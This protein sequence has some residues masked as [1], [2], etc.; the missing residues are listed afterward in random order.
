MSTHSESEVNKSPFIPQPMWRRVLGLP[1]S[2]LGVWSVRCVEAFCVFLCIFIAL[3]WGG[4]RGGFSFF[5]NP[6]LAT[7]VLG[8]LVSGIAGG[9][10]AAM[11]MLKKQE[12]SIVVFLVFLWGVFVLVFA[13]GELAGRR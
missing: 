6:W 5:S 10:M 11:A 4:L 1:G 3:A 13:L 2:N 12:R 9:V 8:M 7:M